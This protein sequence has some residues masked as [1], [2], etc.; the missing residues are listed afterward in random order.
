MNTP[1]RG[2]WQATGSQK[3]NDWRLASL[4]SRSGHL[5]TPCLNPLK[6]K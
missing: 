2:L 6:K 3:R 4:N 5:L 1:A